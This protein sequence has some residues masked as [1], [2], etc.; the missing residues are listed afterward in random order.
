MKT[1]STMTR[2]R[3]VFRSLSAAIF[4]AL[5]FL[6]PASGFGQ[7]GG[8]ADLA[9]TVN[10]VTLGDL[11]F[12]SAV[13][14]VSAQVQN[15]T[16]AAIPFPELI[17]E[18]AVNDQV[19]AR[20]VSPQETGKTLGPRKSA[21]ARIPMALSFAELNRSMGAST[22]DEIPY[23]LYLSA[24]SDDKAGSAM[25]EGTLPRLRLPVLSFMGIVPNSARPTA[26]TS[27]R[28]APASRGGS[29]IVLS[30]N[31]L[32]ASK[33]EFVLTWA[34]SNDNAFPVN[35]E[36]LHYSFSV[37]DLEWAAGFVNQSL[38]VPAHGSAQL[39]VTITIASHS[40]RENILALAAA[41]RPVN[42][43]CRGEA[44]LSPQGGLKKAA[45]WKRTYGFGGAAQ[46]K[47]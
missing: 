46:L 11:D 38:T 4:A 34:V 17:W 8:A 31:S 42:F 24:V 27:T 12:F 40:V 41:G 18:F 2:D 39:P 21:A 30:F 28:T 32:D 19:L 29:T 9:V 37:N 33:V 44:L 6:A 5:L 7:A 26:R 3:R 23:K 22:L 14:Q 20:V 10:S 36:K 1:L 15:T 47:R 13:V 45:P 25:F 16:S 35:L 43:S